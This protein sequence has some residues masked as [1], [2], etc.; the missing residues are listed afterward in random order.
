MIWREGV[1]EAPAIVEGSETY[2]EFEHQ[3]LI[4]PLDTSSF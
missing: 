2:N 1:T 3:L 4:E